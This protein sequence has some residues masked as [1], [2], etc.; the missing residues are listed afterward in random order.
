MKLRRIMAVGMTVALTAT[1]FSGVNVYAKEA[2]P[3]PFKIGFPWIQQTQIQ[4]GF[5]F[6]IM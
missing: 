2:D 4:H 6:T 5:L 1:M 3:E